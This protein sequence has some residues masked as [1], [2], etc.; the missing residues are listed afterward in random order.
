MK[1]KTAQQQI[2]EMV[3]IHG[4]DQVSGWA[5]AHFNYDAEVDEV[6]DIYFNGHWA[7]ESQLISFVRSI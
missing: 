1:M 2:Q 4:V 3:E 5:T 7:T 6:G